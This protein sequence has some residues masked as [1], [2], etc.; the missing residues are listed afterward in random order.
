MLTRSFQRP[1]GGVVADAAAGDGGLRGVVSWW[2]CGRWLRALGD[3]PPRVPRRN[4]SLATLLSDYFVAKN[5]DLNLERHV[6]APGV[7]FLNHAATF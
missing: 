3:G 7:D 4:S 1:S 5:D 2:V 6:L